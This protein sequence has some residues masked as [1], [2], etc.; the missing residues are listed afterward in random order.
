MKILHVIASLA[1]R[2]GGPSKACFEMARAMAARGHEVSIFA[3]NMDGA[4]NLPLSDKMPEIRDG[5]ALH[6]FPVSFPRFWKLSWPMA[7]ALAKAIPEADVVHIHSLYLFHDWVAGDLCH[8]FCVPYLLRPHGTLDPYLYH[9]HRWR[10]MV[11]EMLFQNRVTGRAG[12]MHYTSAEEMH[13]AQPFVGNAPGV[14]VANGLD[15]GEYERLPEKGSFRARYPETAGRQIILFFGRLSFKKG[16]DVLAEAF[17]KV[18]RASEG[19]GDDLHLVIAGPDDEGLAAPMAAHLEAAGLGGR[20]TFTG[21]LM[22][23]DKLAA[24]N[25]ADLFV[26]PSFS[27]NFG[28]SVIEALVCGL[29]VLISDRVNIWREVDSAGAGKVCPP[30]A[31]AFAEN[32]K[33]MLADPAGL[34]QMGKNGK[35][36]VAKAYRWDKIA[37]ELE[38]VYQRLCRGETAP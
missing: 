7:R 2:F 17:E 16:L 24:L 28:V 10:K 35:A 32:M 23:D 4:D 13:L 12:A 33:V 21:M 38:G 5:V 22:G 6:I 31:G 27:E 25:D 30:E 15:M 20:V 9:R 8:R 3:T 14:V 11:M 1:P 26:L 19:N 34:G 18:S 29:P 36:L 37:V